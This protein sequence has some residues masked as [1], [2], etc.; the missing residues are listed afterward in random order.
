MAVR[1]NA[2]APG[3][4]DAPLINIGKERDSV[5]IDR[6]ISH[7]PFKRLA[8]PEEIASAAIFLLSDE[9]GFVTGHVLTVDGGWVAHGPR[10]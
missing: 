2:L 5:E 6:L 4:T 9:A 10:E 3:Y 1:V 8:V 7:V